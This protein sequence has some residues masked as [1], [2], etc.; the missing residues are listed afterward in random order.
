MQFLKQHNTLG[1]L[2]ACYFKMANNFFN[3]GASC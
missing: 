2:F 3:S 1:I